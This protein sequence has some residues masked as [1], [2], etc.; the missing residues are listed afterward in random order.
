RVWTLDGS[1]PA[2]TLKE[3]D[4]RVWGLTFGPDGRLVSLGGDG[5]L[6][7]WEPSAGSASR[8]L[9]QSDR[10]LS[11]VRFS[12]DGSKLAAT[13]CGGDIYL[14]DWPSLKPLQ[15]LRQQGCPTFL[16]WAPDGRHFVTGGGDPVNPSPNEVFVWRVGES[17]PVR[18]LTGHGE[19]PS[20]AAFS[21]DG[22]QL[23]T[24]DWDGVLIVWDF[25][26]GA[27][28]HRVRGHAD[29]VN[30]VAYSPTGRAFASASRD[31]TL[32]IWDRVTGQERAKLQDGELEYF[33]LAFH[34]GGRILAAAGTR[35]DLSATGRVVLWAGADSSP[36]T[37][38]P[39]K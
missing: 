28:R 8:L 27:L 11:S 7:L 35:G 6:R 22:E 12:P 15:T 37:V 26:S 4:E 14:W 10:M 36:S 5:A 30:E 33:A 16:A 21:P 38:T 25:A 17:K 20:C 2:I 34:P 1:A 19:W 32:R 3:N 13:N 29:M 18:I 23:V 31:K 39:Q 24:G 9:F